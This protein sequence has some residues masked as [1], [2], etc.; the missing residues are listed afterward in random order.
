MM[1]KPK[2]EDFVKGEV[3]TPDEVA[4]FLAAQMVYRQ[5]KRILED[6]A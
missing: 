2:L 6:L 4:R 1:D 5:D 3:P